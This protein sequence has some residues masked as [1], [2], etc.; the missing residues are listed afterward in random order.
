LE[1]WFVLAAGYFVN[2]L[3]IKGRRNLK[4]WLKDGINGKWDIRR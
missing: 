2:T 4:N 1:E 3:L